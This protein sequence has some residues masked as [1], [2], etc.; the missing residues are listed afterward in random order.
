VTAETIIASR[1]YVVIARSIATKQSRLSFF[2]AMDC[3]ASLAMTALVATTVDG[4]IAVD[5]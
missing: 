1:E 2:G 4:S 3:F 5:C